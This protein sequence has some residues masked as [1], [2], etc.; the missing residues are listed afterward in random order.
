ML[1]AMLIS[2][3]KASLRLSVFLS[4]HALIEDN[5]YQSNAGQILGRYEWSGPAGEGIRVVCPSGD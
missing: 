1:I 5:Q 2:A 4:L 3:I